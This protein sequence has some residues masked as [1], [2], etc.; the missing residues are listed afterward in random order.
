MATSC[1][2]LTL[3]AACLSLAWLSGCC[4]PNIPLQPPTT[5]S[6]SAI[7][8][9]DPYPI[10]QVD[11]VVAPPAGWRADSIIAESDNTH[12]VFV[13]PTGDTAYGII[14][15]KMPLPVPASWTY[16]SF[17]SNMKERAGEATVI[18]PAQKDDTLPGLRFTVDSGDYRMRINLICKGLRGW[19]VYAGSLRARPENV[20][21]IE[22]AE[23]AR[24]ATVTGLSR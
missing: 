22:L 14:H 21:E 9:S 1:A 11:A 2:R 5:Q 20:R 8:L 23:R 24:D 12:Q 19:S 13:S 18:V 15:F 4:S 7:G 17:L 16:P 10:P 3:S 6:L